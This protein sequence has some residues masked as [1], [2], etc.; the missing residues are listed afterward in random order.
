MWLSQAGRRTVAISAISLTAAIV[1]F[2]FFEATGIYNSGPVQLGG[3]FAGFL[4]TLITLSRVWSP[5]VTVQQP[6]SPPTPPIQEVLKLL[7]LRDS[8]KGTRGS[9][10]KLSDFYDVTR[11]SKF[12]KLECHY[13][14]SGSVKFLRSPTHPHSA[15]PVP[16][17]VTHTGTDGRTFK[18]ALEI[19]IDL[20]NVALGERVPVLSDLEYRN[21]FT[22]EDGDIL[23]THI[24]HQTAH[25]T[26][27]IL[28]PRDMLS[29]SAVGTL[30]LGL[31][32]SEPVTG[33]SP[34][35]LGDGS[36]IYWSVTEPAEG[37]YALHWNWR[38]RG[39]RVA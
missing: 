30:Q 12:L 5:E 28:M 14:T 8:P 6:E 36:A 4:L 16:T 22:G 37:R 39:T 7:D 38:P 17:R 21:A 15:H 20:T 34:V 11:T 2:G 19:E 24:A 29:T 23:E 26:M 31:D 18:E 3:A 1:C 32:D 33:L 27:I 9:I 10:G 25:L 35:L 13:S